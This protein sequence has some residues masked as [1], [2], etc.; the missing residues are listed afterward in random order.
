MSSH[1]RIAFFP[2]ART[3]ARI[4]SKKGVINCVALGQQAE[5]ISRYVNKGDKV[6]IVGKIS[7]RTYDK[8][9]GSKVYVTEII[10]E[11]FDFIES[12]KDKPTTE[13]QTDAFE[14]FGN[15]DIDLPF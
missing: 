9:D 3:A 1:Q 4:R 5:T 12:R 6:G 2:L 13:P 10:V 14:D 15:I 7:T 8:Q 11:G